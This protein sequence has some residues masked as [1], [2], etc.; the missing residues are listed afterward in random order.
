M[1]KHLETVTL[2]TPLPFD[3]VQ[4]YKRTSM[5]YRSDFDVFELIAAAEEELAR[6]SPEQ[7]QTNFQVDTR[8]CLP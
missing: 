5:C 2:S 8:C 7:L 4:F 6:K 3:G 1:T